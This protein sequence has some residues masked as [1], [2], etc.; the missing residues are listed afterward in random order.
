MTVADERGLTK[1][2]MLRSR[3]WSFATSMRLKSGSGRRTGGPDSQ[4]ERQERRGSRVY[5]NTINSAANRLA[6]GLESLIIPQSEKWH[7]LSAAAMNHE[8]TDE[9]KEWA[10]ALRVVPA[11]LTLV[12]PLVPLPGSSP[13]ER[14]EAANDQ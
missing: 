4:V 10:E 14:G 13:R 12:A 6:T 7:G 11:F 9:E 3:W 2:L 5:A 8:E 1:I